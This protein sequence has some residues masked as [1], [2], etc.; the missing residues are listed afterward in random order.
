MKVEL[1]PGDKLVVTLKDTDGE[2]TILYDHGGDNRLRVLADLPDDKGRGGHPSL[3][4]QKIDPNLPDCDPEIY[5]ES[6][7]VHDERDA[8]GLL[9][10]QDQEPGEEWVETSV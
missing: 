1:E 4:D 8:D 6:F 7:G 10:P 5:C 9:I 3:N 2:F